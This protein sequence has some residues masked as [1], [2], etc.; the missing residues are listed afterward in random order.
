MTGISGARTGLSAASSPLEPRFP[1]PRG[2]RI[3]GQKV[4]VMKRIH[5]DSV[6]K[7]GI[8]ETIFG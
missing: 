4:L 5:E 7:S 1:V 8:F 2:F 6:K 3:F